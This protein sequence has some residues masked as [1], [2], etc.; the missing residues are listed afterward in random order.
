MSDLELQGRHGKGFKQHDGVKKQTSQFIDHN[1]NTTT[2]NHLN[3]RNLATV[4]GTSRCR[5]HQKC[6]EQQTEN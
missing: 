3:G 2:S 1:A 5:D 6:Y 4:I